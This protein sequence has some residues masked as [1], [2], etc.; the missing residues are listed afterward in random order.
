MEQLTRKVTQLRKTCNFL[1]ELEVVEENLVQMGLPRNEAKVY[2]YLAKAGEKKARDIAE[3]LSLYRTETYRLLR[4][5]E[6]RGLILSVLGKPLKFVAIP[7]E[8]TIDILIEK[9]RMEIKEFEQKKK[10][11][12]NFWYSIPKAD[13]EIEEKEVFQILQGDKQIILKA[14]SIL[15]RSKR[16]ICMSVSETDLKSLYY[17]GFLDKLRIS[18]RNGVKVSLITENTSRSFFFIR[19]AGLE[20]IDFRTVPKFT[21]FSNNYDYYDS[22]LP[23]FLISDR[24]ELLFLFRRKKHLNNRRNIESV[25][26]WTNCKEL[27][28]IIYAL[29]ISMERIF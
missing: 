17:L 14:N 8:K 7:L 16:E 19:E 11:I 23:F 20:N 26:L 13:A 25:A 3:A 6:R 29:F 15:D 10:D 24:K 5:L 22:V 21:F 28:R 1:E 27:I 18:S 12:I 2:L 4:N 9:K